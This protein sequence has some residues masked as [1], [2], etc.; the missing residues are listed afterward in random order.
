MLTPFQNESTFFSPY[1]V[2]LQSGEYDVVTIAED[3]P[4]VGT[5]TIP[6]MVTWIAVEYIRANN[7]A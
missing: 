6:I 1:V 2:D 5:G 7:N 4:P 3:K